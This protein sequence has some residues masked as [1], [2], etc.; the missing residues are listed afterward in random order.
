MAERLRSDLGFKPLYASLSFSEVSTA[1]VYD[2]STQQLFFGAISGS[3]GGYDLD[4]VANN[5]YISG[6]LYATNPGFGI[7]YANTLSGTLETDTPDLSVFYSDNGALDGVQNFRFN[8]STSNPT[9]TIN[10]DTS[11]LSTKAK[12]SLIG[13]LNSEVELQSRNP[14]I[15]F[16]DVNHDL[17]GALIIACNSESFGFTDNT[18]TEFVNLTPGSGSISASGHLFASLSFDGTAGDGPVVYD[19]ATGQ[20]YYT[21]SFQAPIDSSDQEV[22]YDDQGILTGSIGFKY[23]GYPNGQNSPK[24]TIKG[25]F[26]GA[27][28]MVSS[29]RSSSLISYGNDKGILELRHNYQPPSATDYTK[30]AYI[31]S[32][33]IGTGVKPST[34]RFGG[35]QGNTGVHMRF[36]NGPVILFESFYAISQSH[37]SDYF[38]GAWDPLPGGMVAEQISCSNNVTASKFYGYGD[39]SDPTLA[40]FIGTASWALKAVSSSYIPTLQEVTTAGN[41]TTTNVILSGSL[42]VLGTASINYL[43]TIYETASIIYTSGSTKFGDTSDDT[44]QRTGSMFISGAQFTIPSGSITAS[45]ALIERNAHDG[46]V[47]LT[48]YNTD[49]GSGLTGNDGVEFKFSDASQNQQKAGKILAG[50]DDIYYNNPTQY[51]SNLQFY[52]ALE[53]TDYKRLHISSLGHITASG[54]FSSS[55][56]GTNLIGTASWAVSAS[57]AISSSHAEFASSA[58]YASAST[59]ASYALTASNLGNDPNYLF[60]T[61]SGVLE[62]DQ[63]QVLGTL[64]TSS[65]DGAIYDYTL[66]SAE[67]G[68]RTGQ[69]F[70]THWSGTI[71]YTDT[72]TTHIGPETQRP[73]LSASIDTNRLDVRINFGKGYI[74]KAYVKQL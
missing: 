38:D 59:S 62:F 53:G 29:S 19:T 63:S 43:Q 5:I 46:D 30:T 74:F 54:I 22:I 27:E 57:Q 37:L 33:Q 50:K 13:S 45:D 67:S 21:S 25:N 20:F 60:F 71:E 70:V 61:K 11:N 7:I 44:H 3:E 56:A 17:N 39:L 31:E 26:N 28:I 65:F 47:V 51:S 36:A 6:N 52:T 35:A 8:K 68:S 18:S 34:L 16:D 10:S 64:N 49:S 23:N 73:D 12:L 14:R 40:Q 58:S 42:T 69:F 72:S 66:S 15:T 24:L 2:S 9:V 41:S 32:Y 4:F 48:I 1:V 55:A